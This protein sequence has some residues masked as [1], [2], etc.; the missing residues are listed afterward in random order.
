MYWLENV[1]KF[2]DD[3]NRYYM[4]FCKVRWKNGI[5][6]GIYL[7]KVRYVKKFFVLYFGFFFYCIIDGKLSEK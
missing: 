2:V 4:I 5:L 7:M 3:Y 1:V 6:V